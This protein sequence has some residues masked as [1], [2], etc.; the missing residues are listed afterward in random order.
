M[1]IVES[2]EKIERK[3]PERRVALVTFNQEVTIFGD[4]KA[5]NK[6]VIKEKD[7]ENEKRIR[8][9]LQNCPAYEHIG[10][11]RGKL[12]DEIL[13]FAKIK[14]HFFCIQVNLKVQF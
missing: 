6:T 3:N 8:L 1:A 12:M 13:R 2:L 9:V 7:L 11:N 10:R 5:S 14:I 4:G